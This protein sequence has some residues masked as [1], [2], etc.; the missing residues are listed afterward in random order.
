[1]R[2]AEADRVIARRSSRGKTP[3]HDGVCFHCQQC[4]EEYL[5]ALLEEF[6]LS[7]PKTHDLDDLLD[8]LLPHH[9]TLRSLRRGLKFLTDFAVAT[10]YPGRNA[11]KRE[12]EAALRWEDQ[13]RTEA[14]SLLGIRSPRPRRKKSP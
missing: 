13:V 1:V 8:L 14:R 5:K 2:K 3:L 4:A 6:G 10:R 12:A 9:P 11:S 7:V